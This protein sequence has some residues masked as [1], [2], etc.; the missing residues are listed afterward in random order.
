M[1]GRHPVRSAQALALD[2]TDA[3]ASELRQ[4]PRFFTNCNGVQ[5]AQMADADEAE[6]AFGQLVDSTGV[7]LDFLEGHSVRFPRFSRDHRV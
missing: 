1:T 5:Y 7:E 2:V 4:T 6:R 3:A